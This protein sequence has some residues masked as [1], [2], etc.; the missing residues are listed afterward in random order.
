MHRLLLAVALGASLPLAVVAQCPVSPPSGTIVAAGDEQITGHIP[1]GFSFP[2]AGSTGTGVWTHM[3]ISTNGW[4]MLTNGVTNSAL[5]WNPFGG[6][7]WLYQPPGSNPL[8]APYWTDLITNSVWVDSSPTGTRICWLGAYDNGWPGNRNFY[9]ELSPSGEVRLQY[10]YGT[11]GDNYATVGLS[12]SNGTVMPLD[13]NFLAGT[14]VSQVPAMHMVVPL[15]TMILDETILTFTP[16]GGG[17]RQVLACGM[18][19][20]HT[21]YG[22]GCNA[23]PGEGF[24]QEYGTA[25]QAAADLNGLVLQY[26]VAGNSYSVIRY[27]GPGF[28]MPPTPNASYLVPTD[29]GSELVG[30]PFPMPGPGGPVTHLRVSHNG[31]VHLN[32]AAG[33]PHDGDYTPTGAEFAA[34]PAPAFH[35]W[36][37]FNATEPG[38]SFVTYEQVGAIFYVSWD[39]VES[40]ASPETVNRSW[41]QYQFH[42]YTG[43]VRLVIQSLSS[44]SSL[45]SGS[46]YLVG[47]KGAGAIADPGSAAMMTTLPHTFR[48]TITPP[49]VLSSSSVPLSTNVYGAPVVYDHQSVPELANGIRLG[50]TIVSFAQD[51]P[52]TNLAFLGLPACSLHVGSLD[53]LQSFVGS[54]ANAT[55]TLQL[56]SGVLSGT[57]IHAQAAALV[58]P[59]P[60]NTFGAALSNALATT[61]S[62]R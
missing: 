50:C 31:I 45:G 19:A 60:G 47:Y 14:T 11:P 32:W 2:M 3:R 15:H 18:H 44:N 35:C 52:G 21:A 1:L 51:L 37:D 5:P 8:I 4:V 56:P 42:L 24:Y 58:M 41:F 12:A 57:R 16:Q 46:G 6:V 49:M 23:Q 34:S 40:F 30:L 61:I 20:T 53:L 36:H 26:T 22:Q 38:S 33:S 13:S 17:Y 10:K 43:E 29:D 59:G 39:G 62:F 9:L 25:A 27:A 7:L 28:Y 48:H 55:T 54:S